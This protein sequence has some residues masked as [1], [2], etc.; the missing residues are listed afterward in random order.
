MKKLIL[1]LSL[2][3]LFLFIGCQENQLSE[4]VLNENNA[5]VAK[6]EI[7]DLR[8]FLIDP[9]STSQCKLVGKLTYN[10]E[11]TVLSN[12]T[13][14]L[15]TLLIDIDAWLCGEANHVGYPWVIRQ[16]NTHTFI[17]KNFQNL[18]TTFKSDNERYFVKHY[19]IT[20]RDDLML[21]IKYIVDQYNLRIR[22]ISIAPGQLVSE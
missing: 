4:P 5:S 12:S 13:N 9:A 2:L 18:N 19:K 1:S 21:E 15:I 11:A 7:I 10:H 8:C 17:V 3:F 14:L 22:S 20:N 6:T 16:T